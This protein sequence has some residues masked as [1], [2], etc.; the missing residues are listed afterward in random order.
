MAIVAIGLTFDQAGTFTTPGACNGL[1]RSFIYRKDI[2]SIDSDTWHVVTSSPVSD[3]T[4]AHV[5]SDG[6]GFSIAIVFGNENDRK[7]PD[8]GEIESFMEG[9]LIAS[10]VTKKADSDLA[11]AIELSGKP[12]PSRE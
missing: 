7:F 2:Q 1:T 8:A 12:G 11:L 5:I 4:T 6:S 3:I 9:T 10:A